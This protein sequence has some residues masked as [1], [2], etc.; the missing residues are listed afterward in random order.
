MNKKLLPKIFVAVLFL[1]CGALWLADSVGANI[2]FQF[3]AFWPMIIIGFGVSFLIGAIV[4]KSKGYL[5]F[6]TL[7]VNFGLIFLVAYYS[8]IGFDQLE[9][10]WPLLIGV[11]GMASLV[12]FFV[13][14][15]DI[16]HFKFA[17]LF[18]GTSIAV[19]LANA[20]IV[21]WTVILPIVFVLLG[22]LLLGNI[23]FKKSIPWDLA[24]NELPDYDKNANNDL[25]EPETAVTCEK[26]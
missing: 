21:E 12:M 19:Y 9:L 4:F 24:D 13:R 18:L 26:D 10:T 7:F 15:F 6:F 16:Q 14:G 20:S 25:I 17:V 3:N 8:R 1:V 11:P 22:V 23:I 2:D 5:Y